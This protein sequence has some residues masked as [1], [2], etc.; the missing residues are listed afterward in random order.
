MKKNFHKINNHAVAI[1]KLFTGNCS[2]VGNNIWTISDG[3]K[4]AFDIAHKQNEFSVYI[5][6]HFSLNSFGRTKGELLF[7]V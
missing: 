1:S 6:A 2:R 4:D 7:F 5:L 3:K